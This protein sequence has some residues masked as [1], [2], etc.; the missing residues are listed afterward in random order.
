M[1]IHLAFLTTCAKAAWM[2][3]RSLRNPWGYWAIPRPTRGSGAIAGHVTGHRLRAR[4]GWHAGRDAHTASQRANEY[5]WNQV[6]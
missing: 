2:M 3:S 6:L 1:A 5:W 4:T